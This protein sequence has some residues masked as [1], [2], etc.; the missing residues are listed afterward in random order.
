MHAACIRCVHT[1]VLRLSLTWLAADVAADVLNGESRSSSVSANFDDLWPSC[2]R[3]ITWSRR[4]RATFP[5]SSSWTCCWCWWCC[6]CCCWECC[7]AKERCDLRNVAYWSIFVRP[8]WPWRCCGDDDK[9][10]DWY[11]GGA[12]DLSME[13]DRQRADSE[14]DTFGLAVH[15][16]EGGVAGLK[17]VCAKVMTINDKST[18]KMIYTN[19]DRLLICHIECNCIDG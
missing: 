9:M 4:S 6:C 5:A 8:W 3:C 2:R 14:H 13:D 15:V 16:G 11:E 18:L 7:I 1:L 10:V 17:S 19:D 12:K